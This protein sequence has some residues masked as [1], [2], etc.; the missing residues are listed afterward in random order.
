VVI[1]VN[2]LNEVASGKENEMPN[3]SGCDVCKK[4]ID[5][6]KDQYIVTNKEAQDKDRMSRT[7]G[8]IWS[9]KANQSSE[10]GGSFFGGELSPT[11]GREGNL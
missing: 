7:P 6:D 4:L 2:E 5:L 8:R 11:C 9:V 1:P 3:W 10:P